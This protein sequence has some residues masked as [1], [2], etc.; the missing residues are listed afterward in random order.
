MS[1]SIK[2][3][4]QRMS[5]LLVI[6]IVFG[7]A[8]QAN[9]QTGS[10]TPALGE[11]YL[12]INNVRAR[13]L[14]NGGLFY[15]G[16]PHVYEVPKGGGAT[17]LFAGGFWVG[18]LVDGQLR[19]ASTRY[20]PWEFWAGPIDENGNPPADCSVYDRIWKIGRIDIQNFETDGTASLNL[21][22]WPTGLGAPTL[23]P[24]AEDGLDNDNDG[25]IDEID[26][27]KEIHKEILQQPLSQ[28]IDRVIDLAAGERPQLFGDQMLWWI[29]NDRGNDHNHSDTPPVG[30]EV[31]AMAF[32]FDQAG[33]IGNTTFY[34]VNLFMK[35]NDPLDEAYVSIWSDPD[36]GDF[37][38]DYVGSDTTLG[39]G[40]V[41]NSDN[42]DGSAQ[43]YGEAP[44]AVG[45]DFFQGPIVPSVGDTAR[46]S[47]V[48]VP[49][50]R[51]LAMTSFV[52]FNNTSGPDGDP[53]T[54]TDVYSMMRA[55][56]KD[57]RAIR[58]FGD[59]YNAPDNAPIVDFMFPG[60]P[61]AS[62]FWSELNGDNANTALEP[63]DRRFIMTSGPFTINPGDQQEIVYGI[64]WARGSD[65]LDSVTRM[66]A[67]DRR[68]QAAF[69]VN[70]VLPQP[71]DRPE[72]KFTALDGQLAIEWDNLSTSNNY[73][74]S[75]REFNPL[76]DPDQPDYIFEGYEVIRF[77]S[78]QDQEGTVIATYD[79]SNGVTAIID[80]INEDGI[81]EL[82]T[83]GVDSG[84]QHAH[85]ISG[86]TNYQTYF[87]GVRAY[88]Y[89]EGSIPKAF[90]SPTARTAIQPAIP[91]SVLSEAAVEAAG[92]RG[93]FDIVAVRTTGVGDGVVSADIVNPAS[94]VSADYR[95]EFY[96]LPG[97]T[98]ASVALVS[99]E[100]ANAFDAVPTEWKSAAK[101]PGGATTY[102]VF[103]GETKIFDG[104]ASDEPAPQST[105]VFVADG[106]EF[107][108][109]GPSPGLR[110]FIVTANA[111]GPLDPP[112]IGTFAFNNNGF[113]F[114]EGPG[115]LTD[116][117]T[118]GYQQTNPAVLGWGINVGGGNG[119]F[120]SY[121][122]RSIISRGNL[123]R[124]GPYDYEWRFT[125]EGSLAMRFFEDDV[126]VQVPFEVW[127]TGIGTP[128]DPSDDVRLIPFICESGCGAGATDLVFD[129]TGD[130][131]VSG[132]SDDPFTDWIYW[133]F[134][135]DM[136]PGSAGYD[137]YADGNAHGD[138]YD[139][140]TYADVCCEVLARQ[141]LVNFNAGSAPPYAADL[142]EEGTVFR[143]VANKPNQ[144]GDIHTFSTAGLGA[145]A[146]SLAL[147]QERL[148]DIGIVPNP[149]KGASS[150]E[151][152][153][154][155]DEVR[156]TNL[157]DVATI[158]VF[159]LNG[160][161]LRT[162]VKN[163]PGQ[164]SL[165]WD[166]TTDTL[167]PLASGMYLIHVDVP[168]VG[169][170]VI[171]FGVVK[172]RVQLNVF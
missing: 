2:E 65:F 155:I 152:S 71:P 8:P 102:D 117:P 157:P 107:T 35:S 168:D 121:M 112:D 83:R 29:M 73:L 40:F 23:A 94:V 114:W 79:V 82:T 54:G 153:Q 125:A 32:A 55:R 37:Q 68:A 67:A 36:L 18:G 141:V 145:E 100:E 150:Y 38:D 9:A 64:V 128:D 62:E 104:S 14:N 20:G 126:M 72:V 122:D 140:A 81:T 19:V 30:V 15:R 39:V 105:N 50:F 77:S 57:G 44:P 139:D 170:H 24:A 5:C 34:K 142:P 130:H 31:H 95:V 21:A 43:G 163:S 16:E 158:R 99:P 106:L 85:V 11:A 61:V 46:V 26:E 97:K 124:I 78:E 48:A 171:K 123:D 91:S 159:T 127:Q 131:A 96:S 87:L 25:E 162:I 6:A 172:K 167:L 17:A 118:P 76:G 154:I 133:Y 92:S 93:E 135:T 63:A 53:G 132:G 147:Q 52:R 119:T 110:E 134:P 56:W 1:Y 113:P 90:Y 120:A 59:G 169:E 51:N 115:G 3:V 103:R 161:L 66:R 7:F 49:D 144:P 164:R 160:T 138:V 70:F 156:F 80:D 27:M 149:Y 116:R 22:T 86:L 4:S 166:L 148:K 47:G 129:I 108:I 109:A 89:N 58:A 165:S 60:D 137:A 45:Y 69:D 151:V 84:L 111:A 33:D 41:Y 101:T 75:Y 136:S 74:D 10:C 12:D 28:R 146:P 42:F 143:I 88:A 98:S 13:I